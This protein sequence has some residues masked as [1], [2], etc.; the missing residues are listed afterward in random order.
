MPRDIP[1]G[2]GKL[3]VCFDQDYAIRDLYFPHVGQEDHVGDGYCHFGVWVDQRFSWVDRTWRKDLKY[4]ADTLV[5]QVSLYYSTVTGS[6]RRRISC[7]CNV[8]GKPGYLKRPTTCGRNA[9][10]SFVLPWGRYSADSRLPH[11]FAPFLGKA[12]RRHI[13]EGLRLKFGM[14]PPRT[15]GGTT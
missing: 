10:A 6:R 15:C 12:K 3:L 13:T 14:R 4:S 9:V 1:V 7:A 2:N 5:T 8:I 11:C